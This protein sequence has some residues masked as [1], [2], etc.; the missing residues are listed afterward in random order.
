MKIMTILPTI[1]GKWARCFKG[2]HI[3]ESIVLLIFGSIIVF[4]VD[5]DD[6]KTSLSC[7]LYSYNVFNILILCIF[8]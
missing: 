8:I 3:L 2:A 4:I 5:D 1:K 7:E 6:I